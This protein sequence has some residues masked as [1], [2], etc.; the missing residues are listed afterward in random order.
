[1]VEC[2]EK[3][4][5]ECVK[6]LEALWKDSKVAL[7]HFEDSGFMVTQPDYYVLRINLVSWTPA[8]QASLELILR[9]FA[10]RHRAA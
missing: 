7:V 3:S 2:T 10:G 1:M 6:H 8:K 5:I 4:K 9:A